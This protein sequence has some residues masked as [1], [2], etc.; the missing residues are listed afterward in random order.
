MSSVSPEPDA[1]FEQLLEFLRETRGFDYTEYKRP[2]LMRRFGKRMNAVGV[3]DFSDYRSYLEAEPREVHELFDAILINVTGFFR[4]GDT[5]QFLAEDV[6]PK[7]LEQAAPERELRAWSAGCATGEEPFTVAMLFAEALGDDA[8]RQRVKIY[9]TDVDEDALAQARSAVYPADKVENVPEDFRERYFQPQDDRFVFRSEM[10]RA[11]IFG[12]NDLLQDPPISRVDLVVSRN[13]LMYFG[14]PAQR[15]ILGNFQFALNPDGFLVLGTA[16]ALT[17]HADLFAPYDLARRVFVPMNR[18]G[19]ERP[20]R[21]RRFVVAELAHED[22]PLQDA[23]FQ[24]APMAEIV[25]DTAGNVAAVNQPARSLFGL[26]LTDIGRPLQ[27][28][29]VSYRPLELRSVIEQA[30]NDARTISKREVEWEQTGGQTRYFDIQVT[31]LL[32]RGG[33]LLGVS[34]SFIDVTRYRALQDQLERA[35]RSLE[36]AYE[37]LQSTVEELE[38][39]NEE[40]QSANEELETTNE[41]LQSTNEELETMNEELQS[42]NEELETMNDE[43]RERTDEA[44]RSSVYLGAVLSSIPQTVVVVDRKLL[45]TAWSANAAELWGLREDEV[46]GEHVLDLD[47]GVKFHELR[48]PIRAD[49]GRRGARSGRAQGPR[50]PGECD[51]L[52]RLLRSAERQRRRCRGR[53]ARA[54]GSTGLTAGGGKGYVVPDRGAWRVT[55]AAPRGMTAR[56]PECKRSSTSRNSGNGSQRPRS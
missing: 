34:A 43:L 4:D 51:R 37:E 52:H 35:G 42:T 53:R 17:R 13:T 50:S 45:V 36:T 38:T 19:D 46:L 6:I 56:G 1:G 10:R 23:A 44:L 16:E 39:T 49:A 41:E 22:Q 40:L 55:K 33:E 12:R 26:H 28:L 21:E 32:S 30:Y 8:F 27:D 5:W 7:I 11:V 9:A 15:R 29:E 20:P 54:P 18:T 31:P 3:S 2:S 14:Q 24:Q 25:V 47:L 48:E